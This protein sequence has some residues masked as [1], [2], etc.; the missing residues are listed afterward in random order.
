MKQKRKTEAPKFG[1]YQN[2]TLFLKDAILKNKQVRHKQGKNNQ[3]NY[4]TRDIYPECIFNI[5]IYL[6]LIS[7]YLH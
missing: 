4:L 2:Y 6:Y 3:N 1:H 7:I 5:Y